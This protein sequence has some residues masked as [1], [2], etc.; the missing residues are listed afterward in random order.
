[1][2]NLKEYILFYFLRNY[3]K[4]LYFILI[5]LTLFLTVQIGLIKN[6][7]KYI[8]NKKVINKIVEEKED[9]FSGVIE[10]VKKKEYI[11]KRGDSIYLIA[12]TTEISEKILKYNNPELDKKFYIGQKLKVFNGNY[13]EYEVQEGEELLSIVNKFRIKATDVLRI[14]KLQSNELKSGMKLIIKEPD[15]ES[16]NDKIAQEKIYSEKLKK[17]ERK[18]FVK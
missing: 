5:F 4:I 3:S 10:E 16:Y 18:G 17:I 11:V 8:K 1:M 12:K 2:Y 9:M 15:L 13:I 14:N 7:K 6:Q